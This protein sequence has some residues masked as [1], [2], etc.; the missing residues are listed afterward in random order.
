MRL[1]ERL[2]K[3][4]IWGIMVLL[5][6]HVFVLPMLITA[7][8]LW[9]DWDFFGLSDGG[10]NFAYYTIGLVL[11]FV[12]AGKYLRRSFDSML[13]HPLE[14]VKAFFLAWVIYWGINLA[15]NLV[16]LC[17]D[18]LQVTNPNQTAIEKVANDS[19]GV[20]LALSVFMAPIVEEVIFRGGI[21]CGLYHKSR[22]AAYIVSILAFSFYHVWQHAL[23]GGDLTLLLYALQ[24]VAASF[25]LCWCY[26]KS[27][28]IWVNIAFH[29]SMNALAFLMM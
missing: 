23:V 24:Y 25:A 13:D 4:E 7:G 16:L 28:S 9:W 27:G 5:V 1:Q 17:F 8:K 21:F 15:A 2:Y 10:I 3:R 6:L 19:A 14:G 20:I 26:E 18:F 22:V 11:C 29:M 12:F